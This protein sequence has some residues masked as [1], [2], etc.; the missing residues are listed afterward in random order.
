MWLIKWR[1]R[2]HPIR[3]DIVVVGCSRYATREAAER[4][5]NLFRLT[6]PRNTYYV[7]PA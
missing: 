5:A 6:F 4:Q 3:W 1:D 2:N 7:E